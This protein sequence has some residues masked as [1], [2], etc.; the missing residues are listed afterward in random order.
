MSHAAAAGGWVLLQ[1]CHLEPAWLPALGRLVA[2]LHPETTHPSFRLC[3][4]TQ[5]TSEMPASLL[6]AAVLLVHKA[7]AGTEAAPD[8]TLA[9]ID[10]LPN[11]QLPDLHA[12]AATPCGRAIAT[13]FLDGLAATSGG[14]RSRSS[15]IS[16]G[17]SEE[18]R[19]AQAAAE[20]LAR[21]PPPFD[22]AG[23]RCAAPA[24]G[25]HSMHAVRLRLPQA[26][27]L[28]VPTTLHA[29]SHQHFHQRHDQSNY[30]PG[31]CNTP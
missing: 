11:K 21:L 13:A 19:V 18:G 24:P 8:D 2:S 17:T 27:N 31:Q 30:N 25:Q 20:C 26:T 10:G 15:N 14:S 1:N 23:A 4:T 7:P 12:S 6:D 3:L 22:D 16:V 9:N 28:A 29:S 5:P